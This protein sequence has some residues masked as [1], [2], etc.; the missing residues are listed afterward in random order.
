MTRAE[1]EEI[2]G[3]PAGDYSTFAIETPWC[4]TGLPSV[5]FD[6]MGRAED[7]SEWK[8]NHCFIEIEF[9]VA[10]KVVRKTFGP[11]WPSRRGPKETVLRWF[12]F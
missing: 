6:P 8:G 10:D 1:V 12:G 5:D 9:D 11:C 2:L 4:G 3:V 7:R